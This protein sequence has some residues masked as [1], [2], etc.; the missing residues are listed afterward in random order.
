M[1]FCKYDLRSLRLRQA[2]RVIKGEF[3][4]I[5]GPI[6]ATSSS[7]E[8]LIKAEF[9]PDAKGTTRRRE[10]PDLE[11]MYMV[12]AGSHARC[13]DCTRWRNRTLRGSFPPGLDLYHTRPVY[14]NPM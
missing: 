6:T 12:E 11:S 14:I 10:R 5:Q 7:L 1:S 2:E 9:W 4:Q 3:S 8:K 13:I